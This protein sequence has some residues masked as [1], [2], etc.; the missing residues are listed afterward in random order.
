M[1]A[2]VKRT[3]Q[4]NAPFAGIRRRRR[5]ITRPAFCLDPVNRRVI[6]RAGIFIMHHAGA[7]DHLDQVEVDWLWLPVIGH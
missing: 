4:P 6:G 7:L 1:A 3:T 2:Q 5:I